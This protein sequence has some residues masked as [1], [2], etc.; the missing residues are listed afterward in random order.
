MTSLYV[1]MSC[2]ETAIIAI[3]PWS[4]LSFHNRQEP[5]SN[6]YCTFDCAYFPLKC[7]AVYSG[8]NLTFRRNTLL[9]SSGCSGDEGNRCLR[10][11]GTSLPDRVIPR[12]AAFFV[13]ST[14]MSSN[15]I[16]ILR[17]LPTSLAIFMYHKYKN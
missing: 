11:V 10:N 17:I 5:V 14:M 4:C 2:T 13:V 1:F 15:L 8:K 9:P 12:Q 16:I 7:K 3:I 6:K